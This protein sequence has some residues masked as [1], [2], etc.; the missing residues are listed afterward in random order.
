MPKRS[1]PAGSPTPLNR[2]RF[3]R[4]ATGTLTLPWLVPATIFH[5]AGRAGA[6]DRIT[7]AHIGVGGMGTAH[8]KNMKLF[9]EEGEVNIAAVCEADASRLAKAVAE[10]GPGVTPYR[11][12][13]HILER[14]D[15]DAIIIAT[16]DHWHPVMCIHGCDSGKHVYVEK[17]AS[18][19][20]ADGRAMVNVARRTNRVVQVGSQGRSAKPAHSACTYIRN[21]MLGK[22]HTVTCWHSLNPTGGTDPDSAP[23]PELDWDLWL[24]PLPWRPFN[25]AYLPGTFRWVMESGGGVIR[26]RG[27]HVF[28]VIRW[29]LEADEQHPVTIEATGAPPTK[30]IWDCPPEMKVVYTFKNPDWTLI[31]EQPGDKR[32]R[33]DFGIVF[34]GDKDFLIVSRDGTQVDPMKK[35]HEYVVPPGG[36]T[37]P[38]ID[39]YAD[40]NMNHKVDWFRAIRTGQRP[41]MDIEP[42][43]RSSTLCIL[44]NLSWLLGRKLTWDAQREQVVGDAEANRL[45]QRPQRHPY[46]I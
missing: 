38:R 42:A 32:G 33:E 7:V 27:A 21:G 17:P 36:V 11:D 39:K 10:V 34:H 31:W 37:I 43:H 2:R 22:V 29:C 35:A 24:G 19:A 1:H 16:P 41:I 14:K 26:D 40:Y 28:S 9:R 12:Y 18:V 6:N 46:C 8:L 30:G 5:S 13:R 4:Q 15:V 23:P 25:K 44:G 20:L 45:L 3:L